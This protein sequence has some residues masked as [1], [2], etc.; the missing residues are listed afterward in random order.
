MF[1]STKH[2]ASPNIA[3]QMAPPY[4]TAY[5]KH[6]WMG[7]VPGKQ[8]KQLTD[9]KKV[10][11]SDKHGIVMPRVSSGMDARLEVGLDMGAEWFLRI[12]QLHQALVI[13]QTFVSESCDEISSDALLDDGE[14]A[15][16]Q[17]QEDATEAV[18]SSSELLQQ[19]FQKVFS[20]LSVGSYSVENSLKMWLQLTTM[21][22]AGQPMDMVFSTS[23]S[24]P[25]ISMSP[26]ACKSILNAILTSGHIPSIVW[27]LLFHALTLVL[28]QTVTGDSTDALIAD[29]NLHHILIKFLSQGGSLD[30]FGSANQSQ[31]SCH[32][33]PFNG[34]ISQ[35]C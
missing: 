20:G 34:F 2:S 33:V 8:S 17:E 10:D 11:P 9:L 26:V 27:C 1:G 12:H 23:G 30:V 19:C 13:A 15:L 4:S 28:N 29:S 18:V 25:R 24:P 7:K 21:A 16:E 6:S 3:Y 5:L 32:P 22:D 35:F 14:R 31:V